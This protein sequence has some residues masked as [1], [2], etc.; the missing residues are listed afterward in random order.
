ME[1]YEPGRLNTI[2]YVIKRHIGEDLEMVISVNNWKA[3]LSHLGAACKLSK[4]SGKGNL[5]NSFDMLMTSEVRKLFVCKLAGTH[6][7]AALWNSM[8]IICLPQRRRARTEL[9]ETR[10]GI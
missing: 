5:D 8:V 4:Q 1:E 2:Y 3:M 7:P 6:S 10:F 9:R